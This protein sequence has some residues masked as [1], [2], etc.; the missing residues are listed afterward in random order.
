MIYCMCYASQ[1]HEFFCVPLDL[2]SLQIVYCKLNKCMVSRNGGISCAF[3]E[4]SLEK[5]ISDIADICLAS[6]QYE[7]SCVSSDHNLA[8]MI[9]D[10]TDI[11]MVFFQYGFACVF[12]VD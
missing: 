4:H 11:C 6:L 5:M 9:S 3:A 8:R 10:I 1:L 7:F 2:Q 12:A